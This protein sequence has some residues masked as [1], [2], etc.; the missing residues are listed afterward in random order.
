MIRLLSDRWCVV[1]F[2]E[3][4]EK[5]FN[6]K[7]AHGVRYCSRVFFREFKLHHYDRQTREFVGNCIIVHAV[8]IWSFCWPNQKS[9]RHNHNMNAIGLLSFRCCCCCCRYLICHMI[10]QRPYSRQHKTHKKYE[11][12]RIARGMPEPKTKKLY[13]SYWI[14]YAKICASVNF[15]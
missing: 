6:C 13:G 10:S 11:F 7:C 1:I 8:D 14:M 5:F 2:N 9:T 4:Y 12:K 3:F 15:T